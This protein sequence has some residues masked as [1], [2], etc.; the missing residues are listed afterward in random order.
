MR[1]PAMWTCPTSP[2]PRRHRPLAMAT[3]QPCFFYFSTGFPRRTGPIACLCCALPEDDEV[4]MTSM[5]EPL[6]RKRDTSPP[7]PDTGSSKT[8]SGLIST[9]MPLDSESSLESDD[10]I[11][12]MRTKSR[13]R[14]N[15]ARDAATSTSR[16][17][18]IPWRP[19]LTSMAVWAIVIASAANAFSFYMLLTCLPTYLVRG[20]CLE[21]VCACMSVRVCEC[22]HL[23]VHVCVCLC[24]ACVRVIPTVY[25]EKT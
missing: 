1:L 23:C 15:K 24:L 6:L 14:Y 10:E 18:P 17:E 20:G 8:D 5:S 25:R 16:V 21:C 4:P 12:M 11:V 19:I 13:T 7:R 9:P 22:V 2:L 3:T